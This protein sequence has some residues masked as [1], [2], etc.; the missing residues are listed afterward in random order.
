[1]RLTFVLCLALAACGA[2]N[3]SPPPFPPIV[4]NIPLGTFTIGHCS[5]EPAP[6]FV[7]VVAVR[8]PPEE[9]RMWA[10]VTELPRVRPADPLWR[11]SLHCLNGVP[12][13]VWEDGAVRSVQGI[14]SDERG[15]VYSVSASSGDAGVVGYLNGGFNGFSGRLSISMS[16]VDMPGT[17]QSR[18]LSVTVQR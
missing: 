5:T 1:M 17:A 2:D 8:L 9:R 4:A 10:T 14:I 15:F 16:R 13:D 11:I 6:P 7:N 3:A 18:T 12:I